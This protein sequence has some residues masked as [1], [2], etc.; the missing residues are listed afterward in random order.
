MSKKVEEIF[1]FVSSINS[2]TLKLSRKPAVM[3]HDRIFDERRS[4][5]QALLTPDRVLNRVDTLQI[6]DEYHAF[7]GAMG[8]P[9][10][11]S[12]NWMSTIVDSVGETNLSFSQFITPIENDAAVTKLQRHINDLETE[13]MLNA[14]GNKITPQTTH[15]KLSS[16]KDR[17]R[18]MSRGTEKSFD[19][20]NYFSVHD[21][22]EKTL[23]SAI[24]SL[25]STIAGLMIIP[26]RLYLQSLT[27]YKCMM[28]IVSD[29]L[30]M[31]RHMDTTAVAR[32]IALP[33]RAR[34]AG[35]VDGT[36]IGV[37]YT[38]GIPI[39]YDRFARSNK[40]ANMLVMAQSGAGK[41]F[42]TSLDII[43]Q[44]E[45]GNDVVIFDPKPDYVELVAE[46][47]GTN[48]HITEQSDMGIN[49]F[50][51]GTAP[52]DTLTSKIVE[53][54]TFIGMVVGGVTPA[55]EGALLTC[56]EAI[57]NDRGITVN[58]PATWGQEPPKMIDLYNKLI[59]YINGKLPTDVPLQQS[60]ILSATALLKHLEPSCKGAY[61][62]F[63]SGK[64]TVDLSAKLINYDI[65]AVP[66][67]I[68]DAI[69][70]L[71]LS[72][73]YD[74]MSAR[75]RGFRSVYLEEA[76]ALLSANSEHVRN[77]VKTCRGFGMSL[78]VITQDL[79][80]VT[81]SS[82]GEAIIGNCATK[83]VLSMDVAY[84]EVVGNMVGLTTSE[85]A[86]LPSSG[87][88]EGYIIAAGTAMRFRTPSAPMEKKL[89]EN[90][91]TPKS[92]SERFDTSGDFYPCKG[93]ST[94]QVSTLSSLGLDRISGKRLGRGS[95]DYMIR[96]K[97]KNQ[98]SEHFIMTHLIGQ[99]AKELG[100]DNEIHDYGVDFDVTIRNS[101]GFIIGFEYETGSNNMADVID[102]ADRLN[103]PSEHSGAKEWYFVVPSKLKDKYAEIH[104]NTVTGGQIE[105]LLRNFA[106]MEPNIT[107]ETDDQLTEGQ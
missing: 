70:Y 29:D 27:G 33:G 58:D 14:K 51:L 50:V 19:I 38:T 7:M 81:G 77:I 63:F 41:T 9:G 71:L 85:S 74:Y 21:S 24:A 43:H 3:K 56:V 15:E 20:A 87:K 6:G 98:G 31:T 13:I 90:G 107:V 42:W 82:A 35:G 10:S 88:G 11:L 26:R 16:A 106:T 25:K 75:E 39:V 60:D 2:K 104:A 40:N 23:S 80:D 8:Y 34:I 62:N 99:V 52:S 49:P 100:L 28:P 94:Q 36:I 18:T 95:A 1:R 91:T 84:A 47:G 86:V 96:N 57:Y 64:T 76:W 12:H 65:S 44:I 102:K 30:S 83:I 53:I 78:V 17:M 105:S 4:L 61:K 46:L 103:K 48:V 97:P 5:Y 89:I 59:Q 93:L 55:A 92:V 54:P 68:R 101:Y 37:E 22:N 79:V 66:E 72:H 45:I 69:M 73:T 67:S 32:S